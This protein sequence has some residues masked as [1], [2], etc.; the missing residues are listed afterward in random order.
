MGRERPVDALWHGVGN[1]FSA[2]T[3]PARLLTIRCAN[4]RELPPACSRTFQQKSW[5]QA[6]ASYRKAL[7]LD[8]NDPSTHYNLALTLKY[9]GAARQSAEEFEAALRL[10]PDWA[11]AHYGL[12]AAWYDLHDQ[13]AAL[14]ELQTAVELDP[15]NA[16]VH[17]F[18]ARIY[19]EQNNPS[20][21]KRELTQALESKPSAE[22]HLELGQV[23]GQL[24]NLASAAAEF[25]TTLRLNPQLGRAHSLLGITLRRQGD[26][27]GA[28]LHFRRAVAIDPKDPEVASQFGDGT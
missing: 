7:A 12:G 14:K 20:A 28:L 2:R 4:G 18:L 8:P 24:G 5:D 1:E 23:E 17:R 9:S 10:K 6:I 13:V 21:A 16:G 22:L 15:A 19:V 11:D 27:A 26:H 3:R 25:R